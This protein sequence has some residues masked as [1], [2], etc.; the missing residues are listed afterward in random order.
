M[1]VDGLNDAEEHE[2]VKVRRFLKCSLE[3]GWLY[4]STKY[5]H[6]TALVFCLIELLCD[7]VYF[8]GVRGCF[9]RGSLNRLLFFPQRA[10]SVLDIAEED[11]RTIYR[12]VAAV[13]HI[14][15]IDFELHEDE[16]KGASITSDECMSVLLFTSIDLRLI[17]LYIAHVIASSTARSREIIGN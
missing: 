11:Q 17:A 1:E 4:F 3:R 8:L 10:M 2:I 6:V 13:L 9:P 7:V 14:G 16:A 12:T 5:R 15:N